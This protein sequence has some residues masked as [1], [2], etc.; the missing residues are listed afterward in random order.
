MKTG[1][2]HEDRWLRSFGTQASHIIKNNGGERLF[3]TLLRY[4]Q[5]PYLLWHPF[6]KGSSFSLLCYPNTSCYS[7]LKNVQVIQPEIP[8]L[9]KSSLCQ[10]TCSL[11][12]R[13]IQS[14][15]V[16]HFTSGSHQ[17][18][19]TWSWKTADWHFVQIQS[20]SCLSMA[21]LFNIPHG[22]GQK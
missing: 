11:H 5:R 1:W 21:Q 8:F 19:Q 12:E 2:P 16:P 10:K 18:N 15:P 20:Q 9:R 22:T 3:S 4:K 6:M 13:G 7:P 17:S 14:N